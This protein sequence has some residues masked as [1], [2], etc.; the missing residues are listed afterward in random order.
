[1]TRVVLAFSGGVQTS[2]GIGW[3]KEAHGAEVIGRGEQRGIGQR[4][5]PLADLNRLEPAAVLQALFDRRQDVGSGGVADGHTGDR[6][7]LGVG[8]V[9]VAVHAHFA[10]HLR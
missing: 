3:L 8:E 5:I 9:R 6:Q 7:H 4:A 10:H 1:M 2:T